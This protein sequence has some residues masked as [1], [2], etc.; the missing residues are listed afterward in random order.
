MKRFFRRAAIGLFVVLV[1]VQFWH[2]ARNEATAP[3][4]N[5]INVK[6][7]VPPRVQLLLQHACYDCHSNHTHYPW[8]ASVQPVAWWLTK[9]VNDGKRHLDFSEFGAYTPKRAASK[10]SDLVNEVEEHSMPLKSYTWMHP[11]ARL[12]PEE[13]KLITDWAD[14]LQDELAPP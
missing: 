3:G 11:E 14:G 9:H 13:I 4:P 5:D 12:T 8:Y 10:L 7:P 6:H 2:P 1:A